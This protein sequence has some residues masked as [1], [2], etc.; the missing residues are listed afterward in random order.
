MERLYYSINRLFLI[1]FLYQALF[2]DKSDKSEDNT[3]LAIHV[4]PIYRNG[5][6]VA[7]TVKKL[8]ERG[9]LCR[10]PEWKEWR[11][12]CHTASEVQKLWQKICLLFKPLSV[13]CARSGRA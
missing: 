9:R 1:D 6:A 12:R 8:P 3:N 2:P 13:I 7:V 10:R 11:N 5:D 4:N